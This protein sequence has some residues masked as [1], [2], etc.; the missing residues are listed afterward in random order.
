MNV[1]A[2]T[3]SGIASGSVGGGSNAGSVSAP[4]PERRQSPR[5]SPTSQW[6]F[7]VGNMV[8]GTSGSTSS[9][10]ST[11]AAAAAAATAAAVAGAVA[12]ARQLSE[13]DRAKGDDD[14]VLSGSFSSSSV[15]P[16]EPGVGITHVEFT[17]ALAGSS[18]GVKAASAS[19]ASLSADGEKDG[20]A[21]EDCCGSSSEIV[22]GGFG[23]IKAVGGGG[24]GDR[25]S[26]MELPPR[27]DSGTTA[28]RS[29]S[30]PADVW[31]SSALVSAE[32]AVEGG[33]AGGGSP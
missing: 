12:G 3:S 29:L 19:S 23:D 8:L 32:E 15:A 7:P 6:S 9:A 22:K 30:P 11:V 26:R 20:S 4:S 13:Q 18:G 2:R 25:R 5:P 27:W 1:L 14:D 17:A 31:V 33:E 10:S 16:A 24:C 21:A 28:D